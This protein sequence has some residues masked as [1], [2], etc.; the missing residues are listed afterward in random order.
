LTA[1][2]GVPEDYW[3]KIEA[4]QKKGAISN[5]AQALANLGDL[6]KNCDMM[7][8]EIEGIV[9]QEEQED[10]NVRAILGQKCTFP[11]SSSLNQPYR[12]NTQQYRQKLGMA[13]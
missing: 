2:D 7:I 6:G 11:P 13:S 5:F 4:F 3:T 1:T 10:M 12:M 8:Q 9:N